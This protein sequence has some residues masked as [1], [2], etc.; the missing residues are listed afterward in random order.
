MMRIA[1]VALG[2][3][4]LLALTLGGGCASARRAANRTSPVRVLVYNIHAGK[5]AAGAPNLDSVAA[6]VR[7]TGADIVLLQEVDRDTRRSGGVD[8]P[9]ALARSTGFHAAFGRTLDFDGGQY[10]IA[11]LSR[12][13]I[14]AETLVHLPV[15]PPQERSGGSYEP[16]GALRVEVDA[17]AGRLVVVNTHLDPTGDD[18]WRRQEVQKVIAIVSAARAE[19]GA[20]VIAGGDFN[21]TPES[22]V[23]DALR[24]AALR[25]AWAECGR[26]AG[27]TYPADVGRKRIDYLFLTG[28]LACARAEVVATQASDHRPV[29]V[30]LTV[31]A[32]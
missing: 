1:R 5:D 19:S 11:I 17:P 14:V 28:D 24:G 9:A 32:R 4:A 30:Q 25:D 20:R 18:R 15:D 26:G 6:V 12:W 23:Q 21:S 16:R 29:L 31:P 2:S 27:L 3:T 22:A 8:Q 13:P 7:S 10:G